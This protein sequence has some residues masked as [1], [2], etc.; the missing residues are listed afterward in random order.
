MADDP[1]SGGFGACCGENKIISSKSCGYG[2]VASAFI[3]RKWGGMMEDHAN[4]FIRLHKMLN[5]NSDSKT[6]YI[7][8]LMCKDDFSFS[9]QVSSGHYCS[10]RKDNA[11]F[12]EEVELGYPNK[13]DSLITEYA[14]DKY[15]LTDTVYPYVPI[16]VVNALIRKHYGIYEKEVATNDGV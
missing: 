2:N 1:G 11:R 15:N 9:M 16:D 10:P 6:I 12:Y 3:F 13:A 7:P 5:D 14:E 4:Y 8:R